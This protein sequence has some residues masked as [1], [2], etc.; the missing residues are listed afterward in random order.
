MPLSFIK[1]DLLLMKQHSI[2]AFYC[3]HYPSHPGIYDLCDELGLWVMDEAD[4][5]CHGFYDAVANP[6]DIPESIPCEERKKLT[7]P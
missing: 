1:Q 7:F 3:S 4:L 5:E 6:A 2:N